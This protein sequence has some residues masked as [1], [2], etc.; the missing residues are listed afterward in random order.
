VAK[1]K[2]MQSLYDGLPESVKQHI[3]Q[4]DGNS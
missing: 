1:P 3:S 4:R 2:Q